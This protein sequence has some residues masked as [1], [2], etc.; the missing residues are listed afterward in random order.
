MTHHT[1]RSARHVASLLATATLLALPAVAAPPPPG[2]DLELRRT[3][4]RNLSQQMQLRLEQRLQCINNAG[5]FS[6]L[7]GCQRRYGHPAMGSWGCPMW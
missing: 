6:Q 5:S 4:L 7:E 1:C 3:Q 2:S